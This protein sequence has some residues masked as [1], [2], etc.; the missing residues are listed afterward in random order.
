MF[1][2]LTGNRN[3]CTGPCPQAPYPTRVAPEMLNPKVHGQFC[4]YTH[5]HFL[6]TTKPHFMCRAGPPPSWWMHL[7]AMKSG[8]TSNNGRCPLSA[9]G[10]ASPQHAL[11]GAP[12]SCEGVWAEG[13]SGK[14]WLT[15]ARPG[16]RQAPGSGAGFAGPYLASGPHHA[17]PLGPTHSGPSLTT[18]PAPAPRGLAAK[19]PHLLSPEH[20]CTRSPQPVSPHPAVTPTPISAF[21]G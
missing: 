5:V 2:S 9:L 16:S 14:A 18:A 1:G 6:F 10:R 8:F 7:E 4:V 20:C 19:R 13:R 12:L 21:H 17:G 15:R 3:G 11:A